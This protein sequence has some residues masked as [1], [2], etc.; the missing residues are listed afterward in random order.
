MGYEIDFMPVGE[1]KRG[2]DAIAIRYGN[3]QGNSSEQIIVVI[4]GGTQE[5]GEQLVKHINTFFKTNKVDFVI[6][7]HLHADHSSGLTVVLEKMDVRSLWIHRPWE[8]ASDIKNL[9][10][11]GRITTAG[12]KEN[13]K[14]SLENSYEVEKI[15]HRKKIPVVD[16][17]FSNKTLDGVRLVI[18]SPSVEFYE[19]LIPHFTETPQP[20]ESIRVFEKALVSAK[21][22]INWVKEIW[23]IETL[24]D[25]EENEVNAE[26]NSSVIIL[27]SIDGNNF[28]FTGDAGIEALNEAISKAEALGIDLRKVNRIQMPHHGSKHNVGPT[29]LDFLIGPKIP[30]KKHLKTAY[31]S[32]PKEGDPK[33]PSRKVVNALK[34]RGAEVY[35]TKGSILHHFTQDAPPREGWVN[36]V[37]LDF[38]NE[39]EEDS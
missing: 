16:E 8:H 19:S 23:G 11:D 18:L 31:I 26:N 25:P 38:Y 5:S 9:F 13:L 29:L 6:S 7:T 34:R 33:H 21:E 35:S 17:P 36:A 15:A 12:L 20:K 27:L 22:V 2:G 28:L 37:P 1:G 32:A 4:D 10:K 24:K 30:E 3:L 39:V 14:E